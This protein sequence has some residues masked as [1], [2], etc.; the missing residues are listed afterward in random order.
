MP[1]YNR[2]RLRAAV[3]AFPAAATVMA[4]SSASAQSV[5]E[6]PAIDVTTASPIVKPK[7]SKQTLPEGGI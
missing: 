5:T 6:L 3:L 4:V 7:R 1:P 2:E